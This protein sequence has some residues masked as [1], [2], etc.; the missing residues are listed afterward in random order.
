MVQVMK[1]QTKKIY[2]CKIAKIGSGGEKADNKIYA[3]K[4]AKN[5]LSAEKADFQIFKK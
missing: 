5:G 2:A 4:I 1:R 3:C